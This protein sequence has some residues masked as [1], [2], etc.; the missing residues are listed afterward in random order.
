LALQTASRPCSGFGRKLPDQIGQFHQI[1][2]EQESP[3]IPYGEFRIQARKFS[4]LRWNRPYGAI[5]CLQQQPFA[6]PI[7]SPADA[8]QPTRE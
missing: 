7:V 8:W 4:P 5:V 3:P 2:H 6:M 1:G